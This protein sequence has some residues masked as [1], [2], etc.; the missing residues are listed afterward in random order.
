MEQSRSTRELTN[1]VEAEAEEVSVRSD[2]AVLYSNACLLLLLLEEE[3]DVVVC[4]C[5]CVGS[6]RF[7][8]NS[9]QR[10]EP[11]SMYSDDKWEVAM[12]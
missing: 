11:S 12:R 2:L 3:D 9:Q 6:K 4:V 7:R 5:V 1:E 8:I 10:E